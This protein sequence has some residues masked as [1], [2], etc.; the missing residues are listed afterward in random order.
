MGVLL[1][2]LMVGEGIRVG[3]LAIEFLLGQLV[4][5]PAGAGEVFLALLPLVVSR[6]R[7]GCHFYFVL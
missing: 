7:G 3:A 4:A 2:Q 6:P 5:A 1:G